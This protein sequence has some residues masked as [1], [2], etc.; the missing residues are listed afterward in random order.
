MDLAQVVFEKKARRYTVNL[1]GQ[2]FVGFIQPKMTVRDMFDSLY[3]AWGIH[4]VPRSSFC[5]LATG[6]NAMIP[7]DKNVDKLLA[8]KQPKYV[9]GCTIIS[10][11]IA[12]DLGKETPVRQVFS[13][14]EVMGNVMQKILSGLGLDVASCSI[15]AEGRKMNLND[16]IQPRASISLGEFLASASNTLSLTSSEP[17]PILARQLE[18]EASQARMIASKP[19]GKKMQAKADVNVNKKA[20]SRVPD[21][22]PQ[23]PAHQAPGA[24]SQLRSLDKAAELKISPPS[25]ADFSEHADDESGSE[26]NQKEPQNVPTHPAPMAGPPAAS[27]TPF[28]APLST[29][30]GE[31]FEAVDRE[32]SRSKSLPVPPTKY[33]MNMGMEYYSVMMEKTSYLFYIHLS[34]KELK[35]ETA[36]GKT[37]FQTTFTFVAKKEEPPILDLRVY[38][39]GFEV[40]PFSGRV[41]VLKDAINPPLIIFSVMPVPLKPKTEEGTGMNKPKNQKGPDERNLHVMVTYEGDVVNH[42]VLGVMIQPKHYQIKLGPIRINVSKPIA[43]LI[44]VITSIAASYSVISGILNATASPTVEQAVGSIAPGLVSW[45]AII[46]YF[47]ALIKAIKPLKNTWTAAFA[48]GKLPGMMK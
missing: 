29:S 39:E 9:I 42:T 37:V 8:P 27:A 17:I 18:E 47:V 25:D 1:F 24:V 38:G 45:I 15:Q 48:A 3:D 14:S 16:F 30:D 22:A 6:I 7:E 40:H 46:M 44:S 26:A 10:N 33:T 43:M 5:L 4:T 34:Q 35:I 2:T 11:I 13:L 31:R 20:K 23:G 36:E 19:V 28:P 21:S 12:P 32:K 41:T